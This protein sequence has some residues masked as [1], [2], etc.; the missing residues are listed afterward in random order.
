MRHTLTV[1]ILVL[2]FACANTIKNEHKIEYNLSFSTHPIVNATFPLLI[3]N[4]HLKDT[5]KTIH[6]NDEIENKISQTI[7][8][9]YFNQCSGDSNETYFK[10]RDT[11]IGTI[12]L[13]DSLQTIFLVLLNHFPGGQVNAKALFYNNSSKE[14]INETFDFNIHALYEYSNGNL[15]PSNLKQKLKINFPEIEIVQDN[16]NKTGNFKFNRL[17]HN[18]TANAIET[19]ILKTTAGKLD[20][21]EFKQNWI[22]D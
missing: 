1:L 17:Y 21:L 15:A 13:H 18:G 3:S 2:V 14:F 19:T 6:L 20:T 22:N 8:S 5:Q 4:I 16:K 7:S 9:Y 12:R 11:Y 10:A